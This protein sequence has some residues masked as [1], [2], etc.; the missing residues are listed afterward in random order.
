MIEIREEIYR[1]VL[2]EKPSGF[3]GAWKHNSTAVPIGNSS[4]RRGLD[5]FLQPSNAEFYTN[6]DIFSAEESGN[7]ESEAEWDSDEDTSSEEETVCP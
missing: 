3:L 7:T 6:Q 4:N 5:D 2:Q 1:H